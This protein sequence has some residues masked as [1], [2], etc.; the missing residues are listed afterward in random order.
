MVEVEI[1]GLVPNLVDLPFLLRN[2]EVVA[3]RAHYLSPKDLL[4]IDSVQQMINAGINSFKIEGRMKTP[5]YVAKSVKY[6]CKA[7]D[8]YYKGPLYKLSEA[9]KQNL[10]E[11][12]NRDF[13]EGYLKG[14]KDKALMSHKKPN[15][16]RDVFLDGL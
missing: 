9:E 10:L 2:Q 14:I 16:H 15:N 13:T 11:V 3:P 12:F 1:R 4:L 8:A 5:E 6:Y 7:I